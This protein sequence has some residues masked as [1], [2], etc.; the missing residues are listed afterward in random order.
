MKLKHYRSISLR[1]AFRMSVFLIISMG[2]LCLSFFFIFLHQVHQ[3]VE[4]TS[5]TE[6]NLLKLNV[7]NMI[8]TV[9]LV[10]KLTS[11]RVESVLNTP[12][13]TETILQSIID[14]ANEPDD[15]ISY[16][17]IILDSISMKRMS[18][19]VESPFLFQNDLISAP[20][21][22]PIGIK[23][24]NKR[25]KWYNDV[26]QKSVGIWSAGSTPFRSNTIVAAYLLD[27]K[28]RNGAVLGSMVYLITPLHMLKEMDHLMVTPNCINGLLNEDGEVFIP[29]D[30]TIINLAQ[31]DSR[32]YVD[33]FDTY[34]QLY[35]TMSARHN[36]LFS[37]RFYGQKGWMCFSS[38][39]SRY[40]KIVTFIPFSDLFTSQIIWCF[41][42]V[43]GCTIILIILFV[44]AMRHSIRK[45]F[46]P[47]NKIVKATTQV[48][49]GDFDYPLPY[50]YKGD[51]LQV[52]NDSFSTMR[53]SLLTL[54][55]REKEE[56]ARKERIESELHIARDIQNSMLIPIDP[57]MGVLCW[58]TMEI[59]REVGGDFYH[60]SFKD[61]KLYF[62]IGDVSGKGIPAAMIMSQIVSQIR[63]IEQSSVDIS[64]NI[65]KSLNITSC[66]NNSLCMFTTMIVGCFDTV[67]GDLYI[68]NAGQN[69]PIIIDKDGLVFEYPID[70][71]IPLGLMADYQFSE[72]HIKLPSG[73]TM[74]FYTDGVNEAENKSHN[75]YGVERLL[76]CL[77]GTQNLTLDEITARVKSD[78]EQYTEG[79]ELSDDITM[80]VIRNYNCE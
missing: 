13:C 44:M 38:L 60:H 58:A 12:G 27:L 73:A 46:H 18:V 2:I 70:C 41:V 14:E 16:I 59:A 45:M 17:G 65:L 10:G 79:A 8:E 23:E 21:M 53:Q 48:A 36:G 50:L 5:N 57:S 29:G 51:E 61:G 3:Q 40:W 71:N 19:D 32:S 47:L 56:A 4:E 63:S 43:I 7:D 20:G 28:D 35:D 76:K 37:C 15:A 55:D 52:L 62:T 80:F 34:A 22:E 74:F 75:Q 33:G 30:T 66:N 54:I 72:Q 78:V 6:I 26:R 69:P 24:S 9:E 25:V 49:K 1:I 11:Q 39:P 31:L 77:E 64:N 68:R 67:S 42:A